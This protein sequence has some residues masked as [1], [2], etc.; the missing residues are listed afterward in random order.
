LDAETL[1]FAAPVAWKPKRRNVN[2]KQIGQSHSGCGLLLLDG[3]MSQYIADNT[4]DEIG[5]HRFLN[6]HGQ[7]K[8]AKPVDLSS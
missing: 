6:N 5:H 2:S 3:D 7:A 4:D 1:L 8:G